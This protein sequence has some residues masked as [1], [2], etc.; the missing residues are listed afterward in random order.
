MERIGTQ[1]IG[2]LLR[3]S[4]QRHAD[5]VALVDEQ[6]S[7]TYAHWLKRSARLAN[8]LHAAGISAGDR[9]AVMAQDTAGAL[10][11]YFGVWLA[12]ATLVQVSARLASPELQYLAEDAAISG[13]LWTPGLSAVV[14]GVSGLEDLAFT[15]AIDPSEG[16]R[17]ETLIAAAAS[18]VPADSRSP[19]DTAIIGYT[20]GTSGRP[21]GAVVSHRALTLATLLNTHNM[22]VPRFSRMAFSA[23]LTFC[24]AIWGQVLPHLYVGG[25]ISLL[26]RYDVDSWI[27]HVRSERS[28]WTYLPTPLIADFAA[29]V[30]RNPGILEHLVTTMHAGSLAPRSHVE[31]AVEVLGARYLE[32]YGMTEVVGA[33]ATTIGSD[34]SAGCKAT[35]ILSSAGRP[36][37][38]ASL[39]ILAEDGSPAAVGQEGEI[40]AVVDPAFDGYWRD[41]EKT[42]AVYSGGVFR[43]GDGGRLDEHGYLYVTGRMS[44]M[45]V[46]GGMNVYPAE[47][48]RVLA[49][50]PGVRQAAVFGVPHPKWVEGVAA[51][52]VLAAD[53]D[54]DRE[55]VLE[56]C[57]RELAGYK[58][59]TRIEFVSELPLMASQKVDKRA[60]KERFAEPSL[61]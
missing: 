33:I 7:L 6:R 46:S 20:S 19:E 12:G 17:Y 40:A 48:E 14:D 41:P 23:S 25:T 2:G 4:V 52:I 13:L 53:A 38:N 61:S 60:L 29:G 8:A 35:D 27:A 51:A 31:Q 55:A 44:D 5:R 28:T 18:T 39:W 42:Q 37:A 49:M 21:K 9:V 26:D 43:T 58:K 45:I 50:L 10:E 24:A 15:C 59:P 30:R 56:H 1:T 22:R 16:S 11:A 32:A 3:A 36:L 34:Y 57:R 47:V 54:V